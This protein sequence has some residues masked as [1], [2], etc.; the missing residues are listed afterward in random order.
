MSLH[1]RVLSVLAYKV[2]VFQA[3]HFFVA[4]YNQIL[5]LFDIYFMKFFPSELI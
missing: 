3:I 4:E 5:Q 1:E 2:S